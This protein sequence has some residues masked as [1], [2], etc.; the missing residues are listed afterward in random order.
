[1]PNT[2]DVLK[3]C[4]VEGNIVKL[5]NE[6]LDRNTYTDVAKQLN[7]IGGTWKGGK[8]AGFV[9]QEDPTQLLAQISGGEKRNLKK[10]FQFFG[11]PAALADRLVELANPSEKDAILEPSAGQGAIIHAINRYLSI[12]PDEIF[13]YELMPLNVTFLG[14]IG[15]VSMLGEDFLKHDSNN[16]FDVII[17]NPPFTKN[18]DIDHIRHMFACLK[19]SG[20]LVTVCSPHYRRTSGK[21]ETEFKN[22]LQQ[23]GAEII[24]VPAGT[25][26][27]SGTSIATVIIKIHK[28]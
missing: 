23:L 1:M 14:K 18:Q 26:K 3:G 11:T 5:P 12:E 24:D 4:T 7:L 9:F 2:Q 27:E 25:F 16:K 20:T 28:R 13:C 22:W 10:E 6:Q 8:I 19:E 15:N 17:A 21:K